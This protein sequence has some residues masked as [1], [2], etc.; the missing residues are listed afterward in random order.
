[1]V[2]VVVNDSDKGIIEGNIIVHKGEGKKCKH[3]KKENIC[4]IHEKLYYKQ[5]PCFDFTQVEKSENTLCRLGV[6]IIN[7][8]KKGDSMVDC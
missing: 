6:F 5:T 2:V 7:S 1:M 3:L 4:N 8:M